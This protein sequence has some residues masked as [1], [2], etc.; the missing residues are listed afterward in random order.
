MRVNNSVQNRQNFVVKEV[1]NG[2]Q[3]EQTSAKE[4]GEPEPTCE[5]GRRE[6]T[7]AEKDENCDP[8]TQDG[9]DHQIW[10]RK[11]RIQRSI[12][13][14]D[15]KLVGDE[16]DQGSAKRVC[17]RRKRLVGPVV[18]TVAKSSSTITF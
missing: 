18:K 8:K 6:G 1:D 9:Q 5:L 10:Y 16:E 12:K 14:K 13:L 7:L 2:I 11:R 4:M 17:G 15:Y 3:S